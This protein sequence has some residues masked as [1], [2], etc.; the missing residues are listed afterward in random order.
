MD[1]KQYVGENKI[2]NYATCKK[3]DVS[4]EKEGLPR[5]CRWSKSLPPI[6]G[7]MIQL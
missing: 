1:R 3:Q 7:S 5:F 4:I 2:I 6:F